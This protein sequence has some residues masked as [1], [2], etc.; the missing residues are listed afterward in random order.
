MSQ[1]PQQVRQNGICLIW[2]GRVSGH[3]NPDLKPVLEAPQG[4]QASS[5]LALLPSA[6]HTAKKRNL[7]MTGPPQKVGREK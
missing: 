7:T 4:Q 2:E 6:T 1:R 3:Q 5:V